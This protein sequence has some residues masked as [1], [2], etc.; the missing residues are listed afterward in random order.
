MNTALLV[1]CIIAGIVIVFWVAPALSM[2]IA[3]FC[4]K[5]HKANKGVDPEKEYFKGF[6]EEYRKVVSGLDKLEKEQIEISSFDGKRL[7]GYYCY[8]N[9]NHERLNK[10]AILFHGFRTNPFINLAPMA[11]TLVEMGY[12]IIIP[13]ARGHV[14]SE[15]R[16]TVGMLEQQ[17]VLDW[18]EFAKKKYSPSKIVLGGI[19]M[20]ASSIGYAS[21]RL[22]DVTALI[23][24]CAFVSPYNQMVKE[25]R[26]RHLPG[27]MLIPIM[28]LCGKLQLKKDIKSAVTDSLSKTTIPAFFIHGRKD[29]TVLVSECFKNYEACASKKEMLIVENAGHTAGLICSNGEGKL[30]LKKF[31]LYCEK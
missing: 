26:Q 27:E 3:V 8:T 5:G 21:D 22:K 9:K 14:P 10:L 20:G 16:A 18:V 23:I 30:K 28:R 1:M 24:D 11:M 12:D 2:Y 31:I 25:T 7:I 4:R 29:K 19:S 6:E 17:D 13:Y 15:G